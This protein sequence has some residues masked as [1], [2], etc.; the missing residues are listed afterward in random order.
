MIYDDRVLGEQTSKCKR[1]YV[2]RPI[3]GASVVYSLKQICFHVYN[4]SAEEPCHNH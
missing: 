3:A 4:G 2:R 1:L